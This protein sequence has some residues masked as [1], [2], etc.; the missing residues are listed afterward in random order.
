MIMS[1][2]RIARPA[3]HRVSHGPRAGCARGLRAAAALAAVAAWG[4]ALRA[5]PLSWEDCV[6][7]AAA[8]NPTLESARATVEQA[9]AEVRAA[10]APFLPQVTASGSAGRSHAEQDA[11]DSDSTSYRATLSAEQSLF[12][13]FGHLAA[14]RRSE[15]L[16]AVTE[17]NAQAVDAALGAALRQAFAQLL[18]AQ[19][20]VALAD[21]IRARRRENVS[22]VEL[23]FEAGREN[24]G[25]SLR[26]RAFLRQAEFDLAQARRSVA[27]GQRQ[28]AAVLGRRAAD[29][30]SVTGA[31]DVAALPGQ[32]DFDALALHTPDVRQAEAQTR[33]AREGIRSAKSSFYPSWSA[34][35]TVGRSDEDFLPDKDH[36][37]INTVISYPLFSGGRD[38]EAVRGAQAAQRAADASLTDTVNQ[39]ASAL[40]TRFIAWQDAVERV[41]VQAEFL[42]AAEVR[43]DIARAQYRNGLLSFEDWD[44]IENDLIDKQKA[45]LSS[46]RDAV[47]ARAAW[48]KALGTGLAP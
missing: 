5:A 25:S 14:R 11:G 6:R 18:Y 39:T 34:G 44:L 20:H 16:L 27:A 7:E 22:L 47:L 48:D 29:T 10:L 15:A 31:W 36:W 1:V 23:R 40:E 43:A 2:V 13:G 45:V 19:E 12:A 38:R 21:L 46:R 42:A 3:G 33:V 30:L 4:G 26:S 37:S 28:L 35:A 32:P 41:T 9:R 24:K 17:A 8:S